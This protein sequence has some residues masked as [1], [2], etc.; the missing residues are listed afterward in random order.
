[1]PDQWQQ[2]RELSDSEVEQLDALASQALVSVYGS[3]FYDHWTATSELDY[4]LLE[5]GGLSQIEASDQA[6]LRIQWKQ[7]LRDAFGEADADHVVKGFL[8]HKRA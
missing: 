4:K 2:I 6:D 3:R 5:P 1:M 7:A 8:V